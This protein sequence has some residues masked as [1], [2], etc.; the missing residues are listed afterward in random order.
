M[1]KIL[2]LFSKNF[3][4][5][6]PPFY[7][8]VSPIADFPTFSPA[9]DRGSAPPPTCWA[10]PAT[11]QRKLLTLRGDPTLE[12]LAITAVADF[13]EVD[14]EQTFF[15]KVATQGGRGVGRWGL[16]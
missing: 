8:F 5:L 14:V 13:A 1:R 10:R 7:C 11:L 15:S 16:A 4:H 12:S 2:K 9:F 3:K 6:S